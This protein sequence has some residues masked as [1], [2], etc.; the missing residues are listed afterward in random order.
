M[1]QLPALL[2]ALAAVSAL[3]A[4]ER[5]LP[6][7]PVKYAA[8]PAPVVFP[9]VNPIL[10]FRP[11][12]GWVVSVPPDGSA[13][14]SVAK[15][16]GLGVILSSQDRKM[17][18]AQMAEEATSLARAPVE[19]SPERGYKPG[20]AKPTVLG[21]FEGIVVEP[22]GQIGSI[23]IVQRIHVLRNPKGKCLNLILTGPPD[24]LSAGIRAFFDSIVAIP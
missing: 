6:P 8:S 10:A 23:S 24:P 13:K 20:P 3:L 16:R 19:V 1:K 12:E 2:L 5:K 22:P 15:P 9:R 11:P 17:A 21:G 7:N 4:D 14:M 18:E